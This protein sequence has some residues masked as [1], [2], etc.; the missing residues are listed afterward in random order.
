MDSSALWLVTAAVFVVAMA[1][2]FVP[3]I[4]IGLALML[5]GGAEGVVIVYL[6]TQLALA[7]SF[8]FGRLVPRRCLAQPLADPRLGRGWMG[9]LRAHRYLAL[10]VL[11]NLPGN[12]AVGGAGGIAMAAGASRLFDY[13]RYGL[14]MAVATSPLP[15]L[16]L[17]AQLA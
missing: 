17:A 2:P 8:V 14:T 7:A 11:V 5:I 3:A 6:C 15:L 12:A 13:P 1:L 4:E 16:F 10:A 9:R